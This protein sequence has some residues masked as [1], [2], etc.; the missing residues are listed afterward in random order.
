MPFARSKSEIVFAEELTSGELAERHE[1]VDN[2][3]YDLRWESSDEQ[4]VEEVCV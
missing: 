2:Y 3:N 4:D 1:I